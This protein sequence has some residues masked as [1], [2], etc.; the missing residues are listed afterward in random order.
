[1][2]MKMSCKA[3]MAESAALVGKMG[4]EQLPVYPAGASAGTDGR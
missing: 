2:L 1:M 3:G 4:E